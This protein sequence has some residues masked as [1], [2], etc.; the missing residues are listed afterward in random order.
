MADQA[1]VLNRQMIDFVLRIAR[2][3]PIGA[4]LDFVC[5]QQFQ[6]LKRGAIELIGDAAKIVPETLRRFGVEMY[7]DKAL[8]HIGSHRGQAVPTFIEIEEILFVGHA[9]KL[10]L[11]VILPIVE[12]AEQSWAAGTLFP[13]HH[14]IAA[15]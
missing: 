11:V 2:N 15:M 3:L 1:R 12:G 6:L 9:D 14:D 5:L 8:P 7:K 13:C 4:L 10:A